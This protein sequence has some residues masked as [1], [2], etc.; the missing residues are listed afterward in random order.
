M[1]LASGMAGQFG[2]ASEQTW[3]EHAT[4]DRFVQFVDESVQTEVERLESDSII[5]GARV[6]RSSQWTP[7]LKRSE[8]DIGLEVFDGSIGLL[9]EH[10]MGAVSTTDADTQAGTFEHTFTVGSLEGKGLTVQFGRPTRTG[11]VIPFTYGGAKVVSWSIGLATGEIATLGMSVIAQS[12]VAGESTGGPFALQTAS[13]DP[14]IRPMNFVNGSL[15]LGGSDLCVR[16]A[17]ISGENNL[18]TD[19]VCLGQDVIDEPVE[20]DLREYTAEMEV[21]FGANGSA[22]ELELY[23]RYVNGEEA[24]LSLTVENAAKTHRLTIEGNVRTDGETPTI[25]G[26]EMLTYSLSMK[27]IGTDSDEDAIKMTLISSDSTP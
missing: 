17:E 14:D 19:R 11:A 4:V 18:D 8:G 10:A 22:E 1:P 13:F 9:L 12:E 23:N 26:K 7:A 5:T 20:I 6:M 3:G 27:F 24:E 15:T 16:S 21:E 2:F 25:S